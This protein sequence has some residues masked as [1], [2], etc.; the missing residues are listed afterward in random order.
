M[1][2]ALNRAFKGKA[3]K[4]SHGPAAVNLSFFASYEKRNLLVRKCHC[5]LRA[6]GKAIQE[7][8]KSEDLPYPLTKRVS[9]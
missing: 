2:V 9:F 5:P 6:D 4:I 3:V 7:A 1:M 8:G